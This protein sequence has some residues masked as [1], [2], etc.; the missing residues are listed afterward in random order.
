MPVTNNQIEGT[1]GSCVR[2]LETMLFPRDMHAWGDK[3]QPK[4]T[5]NSLTRAAIIVAGVFALIAALLSFVSMWMQFKSMSIPP[6]QLHMPDRWTSTDMVP[7]R[8]SKTSAPAI[9]RSNITHGA[10]L[11]GCIMGIGSI[12]HRSLLSR[13]LA[14]RL[15]SLHHLHLLAVACQLP[16]RRKVVDHHDAWK[17]SGFTPV[18]TEPLL[19]QG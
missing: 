3:S 14:R 5:G 15:R 10:Y 7:C 8:L 17:S 2:N 1:V 4:G 13:S 16:G 19:L 12:F 6:I 9:C 11:L 18:A